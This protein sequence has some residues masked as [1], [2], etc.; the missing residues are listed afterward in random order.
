MSDGEK[1]IGFLDF[2]VD[3]SKIGYPAFYIR[4]Q[5]RGRK[6]G[7]QMLKETME[8][9]EFKSVSHLQAGVEKDNYA[10]IKTP[11]KAGFQYDCTDEDGMFMYQLRR[12][13]L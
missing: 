12:D 11:E 9:S 7:Y 2:E 4:P 8:L 3:D 13:N 5:D 1:Q 10:S 6:M